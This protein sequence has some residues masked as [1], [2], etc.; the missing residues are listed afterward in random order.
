[1]EPKSKTANETINPKDVVYDLPGRHDV[2][3]LQ[4][5]REAHP[6]QVR[7]DRAGEALAP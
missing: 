7:P 3:D 2:D 6:G 5:V 1:M 4:P